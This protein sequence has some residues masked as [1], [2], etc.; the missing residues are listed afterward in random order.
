MNLIAKEYA[1]AQDPQKGMLVLSEFA[2][3]AEELK[4]AVIVNP[5][6]IPSLVRG[7]KEALEIKVAE[8]RTRMNQMRKRLR[9]K[10]VEKW[11]RTFLDCLKESS[12]DGKRIRRKKV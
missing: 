3:A 4:E 12:Y 2:G 5:Y 1:A 6:S 7:L 11:G 10:T 8:R 9:R